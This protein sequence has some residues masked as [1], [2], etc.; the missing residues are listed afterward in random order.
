MSNLN[1]KFDIYKGWPNGSALELTVKPPAATTVTEGKIVSLSSLS[2]T[3]TATAQTIL[4]P[5]PAAY[6]D[7][8]IDPNAAADFVTAAITDDHVLDTCRNANADMVSLIANEHIFSAA[9]AGA[10]TL[11]GVIGKKRARTTAAG[12]FTVARTA[13][14]CSYFIRP[15][16]L[17]SEDPAST[18]LKADTSSIVTADGG[19]GVVTLIT[20]A[21]AFANALVGDVC[22]ISG[23]AVAGNNTAVLV[24]DV[25][26]IP[27]AITVNLAYAADANSGLPIFQCQVYRPIKSARD[28]TTANP[29]TITSAGSFATIAVGDMVAFI[30]GT[31]VA[32]YGTWYVS[33]IA[34]LPNVIVVEGPAG[35]TITTSAVAD[36]SVAIFRPKASRGNA[37]VTVRKR[38]TRLYDT[39][40]AFTGVVTEGKDQIVMPWPVSLDTTHWDTLTTRWDVLSVVDDHTLAAD[41]SALEELGPDHFIAGFGTNAPYRIDL[42][43]DMAKGTVLTSA[44]VQA[45]DGSLNAPDEAWLVIQGNDQYDGSTTNR[46]ATLKVKTG[47]VWV[48]SSTIADTLVPGDLVSS[49]AGVLAKV[50]AGTGAIGGGAFA[51][52]HLQPVGMVVL[53]N[54]VAGALGELIVVGI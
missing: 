50:T 17:K 22:V 29:A 14:A 24:T 19:A 15:M 12:E 7:V 53:S 52:T 46:L 8:F 51:S 21:G 2:P 40:A 48:T 5:D 37:S 33:N 32:N 49:N 31:E 38:L 39:G 34:G 23:G 26:A 18:Y 10:R 28:A 43:D 47:V 45:A 27:N 13:Q 6:I 35:H 44:R 36:H 30:G 1:S 25:A 42:F 20:K 54:G 41:L 11:Q 9:Y 4:D 3:G 16:I